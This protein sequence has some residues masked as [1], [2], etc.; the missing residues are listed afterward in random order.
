MTI[1]FVAVSR[2]M[3]QQILVLADSFTTYSRHAA[4]VGPTGWIIHIISYL[5]DCHP[6]TDFLINHVMYAANI[7]IVSPSVSELRKLTNCCEKDC[8]I[9]DIT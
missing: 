7:W 3:R 5:V 4:C 8:D 9:C 2:I 6:E 1:T